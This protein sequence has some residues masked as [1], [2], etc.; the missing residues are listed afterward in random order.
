MESLC[1]TD[2]VVKILTALMRLPTNGAGAIGKG[3]SARQWLVVARSCDG[4]HARRATGFFELRTRGSLGIQAEGWRLALTPEEHRKL[5]N[6]LRQ[7]GYLV[8]TDRASTPRTESGKK[9][10]R[11]GRGRRRW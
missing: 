1:I 2:A 4:R 9:R 8:E 7:L 3:T 5:R 11:K 10:P 6:R